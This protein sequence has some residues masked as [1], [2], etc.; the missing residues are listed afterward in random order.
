MS[1]LPN[2]NNEPEWFIIYNRVKKRLNISKRG[3]KDASVNRSE[4][5]YI[6]EFFHRN[7]PDGEKCL[8]MISRI[9]CTDKS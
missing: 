7:W 6:S 8:C 4:T 3:N 2:N 5:D 9:M 1:N